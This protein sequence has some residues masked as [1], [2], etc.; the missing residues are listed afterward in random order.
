[1]VWRKAGDVAVTRGDRP[2][3]GS[4]LVFTDSVALDTATGVTRYTMAGA[5]R[6]DAVGTIGADRSCRRASR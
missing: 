4:T 6:V 5:T 2:G 3:S 1:V